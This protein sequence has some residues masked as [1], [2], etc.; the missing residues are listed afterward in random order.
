MTHWQQLNFEER[1]DVLEITSARTR[2]P[3]LAVEK[4]WWV[5]MVLKALSA[6]RYFDLMSFKG[7]TSLS[8]GWNLIRRFSEDIDI[9]IRRE[10]KFSI[11]STSGNQLAKV[12]RA[13]RHYVVRELPTEI[14]TALKEMGIADFRVEPELTKTDINGNINE[15]RAT[16]HPSTIFV[17]YNSILPEESQYIQPKVKIEI[18]C[19]SMDEP[20]EDK[21]LRSF[22]AEVLQEE[23]DVMVEFPTVVPTRTFLEKI[24]L[25]HEEF[26][27]EYPRSKRM[28][29][30]LYDIEKIMDTDFGQS[31]LDRNLYCD[32]VRH[33]SV[34]NKLDGVD[35]TS[36]NPSTLSF[37]PPEAIMEDWRND[38]I[39]MQNNFIFEDDCLSFDELI[40]RMKELT[41][42]IR[43]YGI[44]N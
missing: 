19:L 7:G 15:L 23:E 5:T 4:D 13:A 3:Q 31:I 9:A 18:S 17:C 40:C 34:F 38:Y 29:R 37:L 11:S 39:S 41:E 22:M 30:H 1:L 16:T 33:R 21:I 26:Q 6:T 14:E 27:K 12:R 43:N 20:V 10:G 36:H 25:L 28:S 8:K 32:V 35:Y 2:L 44:P 42:R 24:F